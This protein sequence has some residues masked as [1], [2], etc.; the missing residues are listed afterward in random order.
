MPPVFSWVQPFK[1]FI[2]N[3]GQWAKDCNS[4]DVQGLGF[5]EQ[6]KIFVKIQVTSLCCQNYGVCG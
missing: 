3:S 6:M 4:S 2:D 1:Q 5:D